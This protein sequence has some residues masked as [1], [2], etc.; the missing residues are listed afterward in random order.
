MASLLAILERFL[1]DAT[2]CFTCAVRLLTREPQGQE[3]Q[4][5]V[6]ELERGLRWTS[7][8]AREKVWR[9]KATTQSSSDAPHAQCAG[10]QT[11][12]CI[13]AAACCF[14]RP[15]RAAVAVQQTC[16]E[17]G[18]SRLAQPRRRNAIRAP[19]ACSE[20]RKRG[21]AVP[22]AA[23]SRHT[24][25]AGVLAAGFDR[26]RRVFLARCEVPPMPV[27]QARGAHGACAAVLTG[28]RS[29]AAS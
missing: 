15:R 2:M 12:G 25:P 3:V 7:E 10:R 13:F 11:S 26:G 23:T 28:P 18:L 6:L 14:H 21:A 29:G 19:R 16:H 20:A 27:R 22:A 9:T 5:L 8:E 24:R 1:F 4:E 17:R